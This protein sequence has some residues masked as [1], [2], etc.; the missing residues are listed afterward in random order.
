LHK[1]DRRGEDGVDIECSRQGENGKILISVKKKPQQKDI[2][3]LEKLASKTAITRIYVYVEEPSVSFNGSME[4]LK[5]RVS[6]WDSEKLT[7]ETFATEPR[8]YLFMVI[9]NTYEVDVFHIVFTFCKRYL[10]YK[11]KGRIHGKVLQADNEMLRLLWQTKDR[12]ASLHKSL[13]SLQT[14]YERMDLPNLDEKNKLEVTNAYLNTIESLHADSLRPL[15]D[16]FAELLKKYPANF[17]QFIEETYGRSNWK[18]FGTFRP[19][20]SPGFI[21][22]S[23]EKDLKESDA[24]K[25]AFE[26][27]GIKDE[28]PGFS[29]ALADVSRILANEAYWFEDTAD[30]LFN[31]GLIGKTMP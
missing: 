29:W 24:I 4:K 23:I 3:Q 25:K 11:E 27:E 16:A 18:F 22:H 12:S 9:E 15:R 6:F 28:E 2:A 1:I 14:L 10:D 5:N 17:E 8:F 26:D 30:D 31:I 20:L 7:F 19:Q 13:R 21:I